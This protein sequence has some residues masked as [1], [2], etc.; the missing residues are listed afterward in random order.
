MSGREARRGGRW[1]KRVPFRLY[2]LQEAAGAG[3]FDANEN[4]A[5]IPTQLINDAIVPDNLKEGFIKRIHH[6]INFAN[7]VAYTLR[8]W[9]AAIAND[10]ESNLSMLYQSPEAVAG[11]PDRV[12]DT[13]YDIP[14][15]DIPFIL[16]TAGEMYVS[17]EW[18]GAPGNV[19]GFVEITGEAGE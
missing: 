7:A 18:T 1:T 19:Q 11:T 13:D 10:L 6:R 14:E 8:I 9:C 12:R 16:A 4:K 5:A 2:L 3:K 15:L 17:F